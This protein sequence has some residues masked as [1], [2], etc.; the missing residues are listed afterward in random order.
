MYQACKSSAIIFL[1]FSVLIACS[2][3]QGAKK[4]EAPT[5]SHTLDETMSPEEKKKEE[6]EIMKLLGISDE[7]TNAVQSEQIQSLG[8]ESENED[9]KIK[10][11]MAENTEY[12]N[13]ISE[14]EK[15]INELRK[16]RS[17]GLLSDDEYTAR[18]NEA[19]NLFMNRRYKNALAIFMDLLDTGKEHPYADNC[20]YWI[21]ECYYGLKMY[22]QALVEFE[23]VFVFSKT[24]KDDDAQIK[25][26]RCYQML[27]ETQKAIEEFTRVLTNYPKS[28]YVP[29]ARSYIEKLR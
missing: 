9:E 21:G 4:E 6:A 17:P 13:R 26:G 20:Q 27:G 7:E 18:Y 12:K 5:V 3:M 22:R 8:N 15:E 29:I 2:C 16:S 23:K 10:N 25:L 14:L 28:E 11:L 19:L 24:E 1:G